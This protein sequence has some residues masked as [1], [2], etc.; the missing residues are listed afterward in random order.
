M[1]VIDN[2]KSLKK[3]KCQF[4]YSSSMEEVFSLHVMADPEHHPTCG[5]WVMHIHDGLPEKLRQ[6]IDEFGAKFGKWLYVLD[7]LGLVLDECANYQCDL[8]LISEKILVLPALDFLYYVLGLCETRLDISKATFAEWYPDEKKCCAELEKRNYDLMEMESVIYMIDHVGAM[9]RKIIEIL[10]GY[11]DAAFS[12]EWGSISEYVKDIIYHEQL[13]LSHM[14]LMEYLTQFHAQLKIRDGLLIFDRHPVLSIPLQDIETLYITPSI[15][16]DSHLHGNVSEGLVNIT[17]NLN[18]RALQISRPIPD[19]YFQT[20]RALSDESR[21]KIL[22]VLWN[23][24]ATTK[25]ISEI[26]RLSP[27]TISIHLKV[28]KEAD[29]VDCR[30]VK[31]FVYY[32]IK[33]ENLLTLQDL[34]LNYLK[35]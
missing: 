14:S 18:Y 31:K 27:S 26:M 29:L 24:D 33:K 20:L 15:F 1:F 30:K 22:K 17:L 9:K 7:L 21:F 10:Q 5:E 34:M 2:E 12:R 35:Y 23:G 28:L 8:S 11:W 6:E 16:G 19:S 32:R 3:V 4:C 13:S 25:E